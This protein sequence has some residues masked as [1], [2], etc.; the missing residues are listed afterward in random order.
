MTDLI[1]RLR[2]GRFIDNF[3]S[4]LPAVAV[5]HKTEI[6]LHRL[7]L[8]ILRFYISEHPLFGRRPQNLMIWK[9]HPTEKVHARCDG[10]Y[11]NL[12]ASR[13]SFS[14]NKPESFK[15][16]TTSCATTF[17]PPTTIPCENSRWAFLMFFIVSGSKSV[18]SVLLKFSV[19]DRT[20]VES[21]KTWVKET[22]GRLFS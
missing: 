17:L 21:W 8:S 3:L 14:V 12:N 19:T 11:K 1:G 18:P 16:D 10:L 15:S 13:Q 4:Q 6:R 7:F 2:L 9:M 20:G 22:F 5:A